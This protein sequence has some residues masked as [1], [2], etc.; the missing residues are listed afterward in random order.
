G[1]GTGLGLATCYGILKQSGGHINVYS[2]PGA[3]TTFRL[4]LPRDRQGA[5]ATDGAESVHQAAGQGETVVIVEDN[6]PMRRIVGR[7]LAELGY[8]VIEADG[9]AAALELLGRE[10]PALLFSDIVMPGEMNG[11]ALAHEA[12]ARWPALKVI[13]TSGFPDIRLGGDGDAVAG[14]RLLSKPYRRAELAAAVRD[15]LEPG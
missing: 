1:Q 8:R 9:A 10:R 11:I 5:A 6:L 3:G 4:Y 2:E 14:I 13:L 12:I 7:Q 15:A